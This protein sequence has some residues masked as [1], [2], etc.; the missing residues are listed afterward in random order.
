[1][2]LYRS[3]QLCVLSITVV[4][5]AACGAGSSVKDPF[6]PN[7]LVV[8]GDGLND[9]SATAFTVNDGST[10]NW[11]LQI[12]ASYPTPITSFVKN[13]AGNALVAA[14]AAQVSTFGGAYQSGDLTVMSAGF[15]DLIDLGQ[16]SQSIASATALGDAYANAVRAAVANGAKHV[17]VSNV[18]DFSASYAAQ[19]GLASAATMKS[20]IRAFNDALKTNLGS[21]T[22]AYLGDNVRLIDAEYYMNLVFATPTSYSFTD[23][24]TLA[25]T[26]LGATTGVGT[27]DSSI[28]NANT[29]IANYNSY[30]Y[31][32]AVYLTPAAHRSLGGYAYGLLLTRW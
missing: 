7:R 31:A 27:I 8:F 29:V 24:S 25:C 26:S 9:A 19:G 21:S 18:Y 13:A 22:A 3:L 15:R 32:D 4:L 17:A 12:A 11:S 14:V 1:M 16:G 30:V 2:T 23:A 20:L 10:N 28:C 6:A 5:V